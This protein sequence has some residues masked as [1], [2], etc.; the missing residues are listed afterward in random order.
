MP[1]TVYVMEAANLICGDTGDQTSPG[2]STHLTLSELKLPGFDENYVDHVAGGAPVAIEVATHFPRLEATFNLMGWQPDVM[3]MIAASD[4]SQQVFTAYGL[5]RDRRSGA[6]IPA[7]AIMEGRLGRA[8]PQ[9]WR[10]GDAM[11]FEYSIRSIVHYE[12]YMGTAGSPDG[13]QGALAEIYFWDFFT[14]EFRVTSN[15]IVRNVNADMINLLAIPGV[16]I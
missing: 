16:A 12:L 1:N 11:H 10:R 7:K 8:N 3:G 6:A 15:G 2:Q 13:S 14:S 9:N 4:I 5:I